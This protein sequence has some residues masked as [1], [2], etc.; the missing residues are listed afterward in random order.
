MRWDDSARR[1][2]LPGAPA[3]RLP[4]VLSRRVSR[5]SLPSPVTVAVAG[6]VAFAVLATGGCAWGTAPGGASPASHTAPAT[7]DSSAVQASSAPS[8][9]P[10]VRDLPAATSP[11]AQPAASADASPRSPVP[12][13]ASSRPLANVA[14]TYSLWDPATASVEVA[15]Y[16]TDIVE[17]GGTCTLTLTSA[18]RTVSVT[19]KATADATTTSCG[20]LSI[21]RA[22]LPGSGA[23]SA[24]LSYTSS[25]HAGSAPAV[26][27][28]VP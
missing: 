25:E 26:T 13:S 2:R 1:D 20:M 19:Q 8:P 15:G 28:E 10:S 21:P 16:V 3:D 22:K 9:E 12:N 14:V 4:S 7:G 18:G 27:V 11:A 24:V 17:S 6:S 5:R 23:L